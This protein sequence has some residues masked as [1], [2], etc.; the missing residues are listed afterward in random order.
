MWREVALCFLPRCTACWALSP[1][2]E[3]PQGSHLGSV[4][5]QT[6]FLELLLGGVGEAQGV[7]GESCWERSC[8]Q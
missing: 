3:G 6:L 5:H 8:Q 1:V 2:A 4:F 7:C